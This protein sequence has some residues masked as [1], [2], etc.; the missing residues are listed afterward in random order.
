M[1]CREW[2]GVLPFSSPGT[3]RAAASALELANEDKLSLPGMLRIPREQAPKNV[4]WHALR[5]EGRGFER[6]AT[7][8]AEAQGRATQHFLYQ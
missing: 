3:L 4:G 7:P 8:F 6:F 1:N 2:D 5:H